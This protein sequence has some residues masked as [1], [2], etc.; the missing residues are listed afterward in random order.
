LDLGWVAWAE[1]LQEIQDQLFF[2]EELG[3]Y[4][5]NVA[6]PDLLIRMKDDNDNV[7]PSGNSV[8]VRNG[9]RLAKLTGKTH[10]SNN[11]Q[12]TVQAFA[13]R[14]K[15]NPAAITAMVSALADSCAT[16]RI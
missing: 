16:P 7:I 4:F 9:L 10:F 13:G 12:K 6:R 5:M 11:A 1:Q 14:L 2:D 8:A 3:G 15:T